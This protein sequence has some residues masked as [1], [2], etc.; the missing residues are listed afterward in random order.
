MLLSALTLQGPL[1]EVTSMN[2]A[3]AVAFADDTFLQ[4]APEPTMRAFQALVDLATPLGL[5]VQPAKCVVYSANAAAA[6]FVATRLGVQHAHDGLLATGTAL[7][8]ASFQAARADACADHA[9]TLIDR[10]QALPLLDQ[11]RWILLHRS[12]QLRVAHLPRSSQW[13]HVG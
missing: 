2:L 9:C 12:L 8:A 1:E 13:E 7:S 5:E 3:R 10:M 6:T 4:G 11:D